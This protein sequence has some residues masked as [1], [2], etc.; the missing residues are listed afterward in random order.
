MAETRSIGRFVVGPA[1]ERGTCF[2]CGKPG[3]WRNECPL[4]VVA[5]GQPEGKKLSNHF[6]DLCDS[7]FISESNDAFE[8]VSEIESDLK[9]VGREIF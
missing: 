3:H 2:T 9:P 8:H 6:I 7:E 1:Q 4:L 5:Q